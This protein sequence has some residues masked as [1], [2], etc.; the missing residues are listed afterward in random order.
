ML[1]HDR[2]FVAP[3][4]DGSRSETPRRDAGGTQ[5]RHSE[6]FQASHCK[7]TKL[8]PSLFTGSQDQYFLDVGSKHDKKYQHS[9]VG[10]AFELSFAVGAGCCR[11][12]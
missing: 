11:M 2:L 12:W 3:V 4:T 10:S 7:G 1:Y 5:W 6:Q 8:F 9:T